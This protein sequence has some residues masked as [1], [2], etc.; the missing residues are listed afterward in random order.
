MLGP[1]TLGV[2]GT[3]QNSQCSVNAG[4]SSAT[5]SGNNLTVN[6]AIT[7]T[8][9]FVGTQTIYMRADDNGGLTSNWQSMG[10]WTVP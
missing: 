8:T 7:F 10:T 9:A 3:L 6:L 5:G 2:A 4:S 1:V